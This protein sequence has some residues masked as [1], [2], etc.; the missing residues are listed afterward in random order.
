MQV[1]VADTGV[2]DFNLNV[3]VAD[4]MAG[5]LVR[6]EGVLRGE[7]GESLR[8]DTLVLVLCDGRSEEGKRR[9]GCNYYPF[10]ICLI[11]NCY[12]VR[13]KIRAFSHAARYLSYGQKY[14]NYGFC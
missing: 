1:A 7:H 11:L 13:C 5:K 12:F 4:S 9:H 8:G 10:H 14:P 3:V 6:M 2:Q